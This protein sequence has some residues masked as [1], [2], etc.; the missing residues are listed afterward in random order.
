M[1]A[2]ATSKSA[3]IW[4]RTLSMPWMDWK[5]G[6]R[7][8]S[9]VASK[10]ASIVRARR[11]LS[12]Q[13]QCCC[14]SYFT[15]T[16]EIKRYDPY[17]QLGLQY[18]DGATLADIKR[19]Y[20]AKSLELHP[21]R[22]PGNKAAAQRAFADLQRAYETLVKV[23]SNL[24][25]MNSEK[26]A[27][28]RTSV[29]RNGDRLAINRTDV[30]GVRKKRPAPAASLQSTA[31][32][33]GLIGSLTTMARPAEFIGNGSKK[34]TPS[35]SVG[36]GLNKWVKLKELKPWNG[37][38]ATRASDFQTSTKNQQEEKERHTPR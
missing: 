30:A 1:I 20:K 15:N 21:D 19:A 27:E 24:N 22:N 4:R 13:H 17:A 38:A 16:D 33:A 3:A 31:A 35:S 29:W 25:G 37:K 18:G 2:S 6:K 14:R 10:S 9:T 12:I 7:V 26:D 36:R 28:W 23:H 8:I 5:E 11:L 34:A 32:Q